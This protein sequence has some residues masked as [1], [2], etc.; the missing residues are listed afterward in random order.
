MR[1]IL[2]KGHEKSITHLTYN[3]EGDLLFTCSKADFPTVWWSDN[4]ERIGTYNGHNGAVWYLDVTRDS[5][6]LLT[7]SADSTVKLWMVETGKELFT[8]KYK[9]SVKCCAWALG[10]RLFLAVTD[11]VM[12]Q[13]S[14]IHIQRLA[15]DLNSQQQESLRVIPA[16]PPMPTSLT[17]SATPATS[18]K[19]LHALWGPLN[20]HIFT[21]HD[22][23]T[24]RVYDVE[25]GKFTAVSTVHKRAVNRIQFDKH[26]ITFISASRDGTAKL[27]DTKTLQCLK[28]YETGRPVNAASISP[29]MDHVMLSFS[30]FVDSF[31]FVC[32]LKSPIA[33]LLSLFVCGHLL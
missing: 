30:R 1:P 17:T 33:T 19:I 26:Q 32:W 18:A 24:I 3:R 29:I 11:Q 5:K 14:A 4:G 20:T 31:L 9:V 10:D 27:F 12:G 6:Y 28:T 8:F 7:A 15:D 23:G 13:S 2:L 25:A 22:D 21:C 16:P